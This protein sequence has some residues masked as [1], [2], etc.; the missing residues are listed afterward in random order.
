MPRLR[1][2]LVYV[3]PP[4]CAELLGAGVRLRG[5]RRLV[6]A[7]AHV[8]EGGADVAVEAGADLDQDRALVGDDDLGVGRSPG[9]AQGGEDLVDVRGELGDEG[10][11]LRVGEQ[12]AVVDVLA[13]RQQCLLV[14]PDPAHIALTA[15]A[16][17]VLGALEI[18]RHEDLGVGDAEHV[19]GVDDAAGGGTDRVGAG[20]DDDAVGGGRAERLDD[21]RVAA[22]L[23]GPGHRGVRVVGLEL[24]YAAH[25]RPPQRLGRL[26]LVPAGRRQRRAVGRH[27]D[28]LAQP[29]G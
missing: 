16:D 14:L 6:V 1:R 22:V 8:V 5:E 3:R 24:P 10:V 19:R 4:Y 28:R 29:V 23:L 15:A 26:V 13:G 25:S 18:G 2:N 17:D 12:V 7:Q 27:A 11:G 20:A 9:D 21:D